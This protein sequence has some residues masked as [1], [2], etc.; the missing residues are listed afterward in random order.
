MV[1]FRLS[2]TYSFRTPYYGSQNVR[3]SAEIGDS[4]RPPL[5]TAADGAVAAAQM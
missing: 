1:D 2:E 5:W 3:F 4:L